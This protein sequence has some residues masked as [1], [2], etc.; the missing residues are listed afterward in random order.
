MLARKERGSP[1]RSRDANM[2]L[3]ESFSKTANEENMFASRDHSADIGTRQPFEMDSP[4]T[5]SPQDLGFAQR[6]S[7]QGITKVSDEEQF[8][9]ERGNISNNSYERASKTL[10]MH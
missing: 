2:D 4:T 6:S 8:R 9:N 3:V 7:N 5:R 10:Y 1:Y